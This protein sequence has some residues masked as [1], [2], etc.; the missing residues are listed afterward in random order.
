MKTIRV[1]SHYVNP[2]HIITVEFKQVPVRG[3]GGSVQN[4]PAAA[5]RVMG[6]QDEI[7]TTDA[8]SIEALRAHLES[9]LELGV[10]V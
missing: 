3:A 9:N 2:A 7:R 6:L 5:L 4:L 1:G 10:D 8:R